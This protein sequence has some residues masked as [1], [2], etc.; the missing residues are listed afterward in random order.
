VRYHHEISLELLPE[1]FYLVYALRK[2]DRKTLIG[3]I[4]K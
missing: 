2:E 3:T 1:G 4:L